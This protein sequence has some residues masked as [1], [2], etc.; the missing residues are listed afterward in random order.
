MCG[1]CTG[2]SGTSRSSRATGRGTT[3]RKINYAL[4]TLLLGGH[5]FAPA[6]A[7]PDCSSVL[8]LIVGGL[9][10]FVVQ[11]KG[12]PYHLQSAVIGVHL[13]WVVGRGLLR[14]AR[15]PDAARRAGSAAATTS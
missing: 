10:S 12:F 11:G 7:A 2:T 14:R 5:R 8:S 6:L 15:W 13:L 9:A 1:G 3:R 4:A